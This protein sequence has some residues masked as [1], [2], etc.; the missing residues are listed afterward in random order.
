LFVVGVVCLF[1]C[2]FLRQGL[3]MQS[4]WPVTH[5]VD[6][7]VWNSQSSSCLCLL[8]AG[9]KGMHCHVWLY[10]ENGFGFVLFYHYLFKY[11]FDLSPS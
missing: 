1:V 6:Q 5:N 3:T 11:F 2:L 4:G 9:I 7:L 8:S 10:L